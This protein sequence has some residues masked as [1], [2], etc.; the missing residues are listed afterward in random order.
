MSKAALKAIGE[1]IRQSKWGDAIEQARQFVQKEPKSF[2]GY[3]H[4]CTLM[5]VNISKS[6]LITR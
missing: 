6:T 4:L 1:L 2:Q 3:V 5:F